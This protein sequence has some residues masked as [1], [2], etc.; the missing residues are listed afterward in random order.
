MGIEKD[1]LEDMSLAMAFYLQ[2]H[3]VIDSEEEDRLKVTDVVKEL[4]ANNEIRLV[5]ARLD[6]R[7]FDP[8]SKNEL[9]RKLAVKIGLQGER[10]LFLRARLRRRLLRHQQ[11]RSRLWQR[12]RY[13]CPAPTAGHALLQLLLCGT[14]RT[15]G[16]CRHR[17]GKQE[18]IDGERNIV[19]RRMEAH[20]GHEDHGK[21]A[22]D[23]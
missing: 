6:F 2:Q 20:E 16:L 13:C 19:R 4:L 17:Q 3:G 21:V 18:A 10:R 23:L 7:V 5:S 8:A 9:L 1:V 22:D 15:L 11:R 12:A 14:P